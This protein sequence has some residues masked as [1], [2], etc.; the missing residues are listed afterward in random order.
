MPDTEAGRVSLEVRRKFASQLIEEAK[1]HR[2]DVHANSKWHKAKTLV[3]SKGRSQ[4]KALSYKA[5]KAPAAL[6]PFHLG[7]VVTFAM[8][9]VRSKV[10]TSVMQ[11]KL[12]RY[13]STV[14][15]ATS[16]DEGRSEAKWRGKDL[17]RL[18]EKI[19]GNRV[20]LDKAQALSHQSLIKV[21]QGGADADVEDLH[22]AVR[23]L[24]DA[25]HYLLKLDQLILAASQDLARVQAYVDQQLVRQDI[26]EA[27]MHAHLT[28][29]Y[30]RFGGDVTQVAGVTS[31]NRQGYSKVD[32]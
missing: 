22:K 20:K 1:D 7:G 11:K 28:E 30:E 31:V 25:G 2:K 9:Q 26:L 12:Q 21:V 4:L 17:A 14:A 3:K 32:G 15:D 16:L 23:D 5:L 10:M 6:I 8:D 13:G 19:D 24:M 29:N 18:A 27:D